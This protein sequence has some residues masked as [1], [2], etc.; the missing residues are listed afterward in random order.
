M[1]NRLVLLMLAA[2]AG[3]MPAAPAPAA[4]IDDF[5]NYSYLDD[6]SNPLL[7]GLLHVPAGHATDP[8][9]PRPLVLFLHGAGESG[10]DNLRQINGNIDNLLA[11]AK[12]NDAF[13]YAPQTNMGWSSTALFSHAMEMIDR[14]IAERNVDPNRIYVTGLS[15]GGGGV[16]NF[17]NQ[18]HDRVAA[19]VPICA[20]GPTASFMPA[21][22]LGESIWA[23]HGRS[24][25]TVPV[26]ETRS[27]I[28]SLLTEAGLA[29][30]DYPPTSSTFTPNTTFDFPP[31]DLHYTDMRGNHDIWSQVYNNAQMH[32]WMFSR[33]QVIPEPG[34]LAFLQLA[35][36]VFAA[37]RRRRNDAQQP[38]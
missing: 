3:S 5:I 38:G 25:H 12:N 19:A 30:P 17:V 6:M 9:T 15:M 23:F 16:W 36:C 29:I 28:N 24:D 7:R 20:V 14:A 27:V 21:D 26:A 13:L 34:T 22:L 32:D 8:D 31:L 2:A 4:S 35:V 18:F 33:G 11:A 10:T 1:R 37:C